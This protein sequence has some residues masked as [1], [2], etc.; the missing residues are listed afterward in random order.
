MGGDGVGVDGVGAAAAAAA[1]AATKASAAA[2][3]AAAAVIAGLAAAAAAAAGLAAAAAAAASGPAEKHVGA[4]GGVE[5][6]QPSDVAWALVLGTAA[7]PGFTWRPHRF[8]PVVT[9]ICTAAVQLGRT[10][11]SDDKATVVAGV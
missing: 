9:H 7:C 4:C 3:A 2:A 11:T 10:L 6:G 1:A 8:V 5:P